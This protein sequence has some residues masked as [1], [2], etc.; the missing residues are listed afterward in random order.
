MFLADTVEAK[1]TQSYVPQ[2]GN[3]TPDPTV[4][5]KEPF[6]VL[7]LGSDKRD[8]EKSRGRSDAVIYAVVRPKESRVL[9]VSIPR[10]T[11]VQIVGEMRTR[12]G[13]MITTKLRMLT[14]SVGKICPSIRWR[15]FLMPTS[16]ITQRLTFRE[17]KSG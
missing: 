17:S 10:D 16:V 9:L 3:K 13:R 1:L 15:S 5:R 11:Y 8:Y 2:E 6:S 12:T 4:Y 14:P 7:L